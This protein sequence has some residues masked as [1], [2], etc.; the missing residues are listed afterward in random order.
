MSDDFSS[1]VYFDDVTESNWASVKLLNGTLST[2]KVKE[3]II[4]EM[5]NLQ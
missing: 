5:N 3:T 2:E 1:I 4:N